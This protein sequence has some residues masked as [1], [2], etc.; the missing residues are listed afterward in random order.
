MKFGLF[1]GARA[2]GGP[3]GDSYAYHDFVNYVIEAEKLGFT[4]VFLVE[5]HFTGF[6][7]VSASMSLLAYLARQITKEE[8]LQRIEVRVF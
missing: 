2:R 4:S 8:A 1:G 5:H 7:Q 6:G 3:A